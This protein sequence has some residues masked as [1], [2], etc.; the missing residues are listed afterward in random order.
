MCIMTF[1][2][3]SHY[4]ALAN[5]GTAEICVGYTDEHPIS[6]FLVL[7]PKIEKNNFTH[8]VTFLGK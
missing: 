3:N 1:C 6:T 2:D 8:D 7:N 4:A 5:Q